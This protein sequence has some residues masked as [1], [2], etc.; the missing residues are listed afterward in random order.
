MPIEG[1]VLQMKS[2][3]IDTV[4]NFPFPTIPDQ[5]SLRKAETL[6]TRLGALDLPAGMTLGNGLATAITLTG[7]HITD[8]GKIMAL[9]PLSP[10]FSK[11]LVSGSQHACLPYV[12]AAVSVSSVGDPF[13]H[14]EHLDL[15]EM[16]SEETHAEDLSHITNEEIKSKEEHKLLRR[17]YMQS[18]QVSIYDFFTRD[19]LLRLSAPDSSTTRQWTKRCVHIFVSCW[20]I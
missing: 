20:C 6:L 13:I 18:R 11:M 5:L 15:S 17:A 16:P 14:E 1:V 8:V 9:F 10:R 7:G 4:S 3:H 12:I 2:M 19:Y